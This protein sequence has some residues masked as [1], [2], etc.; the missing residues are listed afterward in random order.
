MGWND[1]VEHH[2]TECLDCGEVDTWEYWADAGRERYVGPVGEVFGVD[3][4]RSGKC[5]HF[6]SIRGQITDDD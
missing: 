6:G 2:E 1:H 3:A 5:P 4:E